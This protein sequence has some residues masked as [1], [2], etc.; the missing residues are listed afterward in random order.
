MTN[1]KYVQVPKHVSLCI[2]KKVI[3]IKKITNPILFQKFN[4]PLI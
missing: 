1:L 3:T 2:K 4:S